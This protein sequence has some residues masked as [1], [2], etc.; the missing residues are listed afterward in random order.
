MAKLIGRQPFHAFQFEGQRHDCGNA[1]GFVIANI[2]LALER[3]DV[4]PRVRD[5]LN[6][7]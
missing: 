6:T 2:A 3:S 5:Y 4:G 1:P 7:L